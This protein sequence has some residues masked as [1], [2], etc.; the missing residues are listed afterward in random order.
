M[1][2][3]PDLLKPEEKEAAWF[4]WESL[5]IPVGTILLGTLLSSGIFSA[6]SMMWAM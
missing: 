4:A 2:R 3:N 6:V 1:M 5:H